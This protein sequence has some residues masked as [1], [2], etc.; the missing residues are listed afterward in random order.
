MKRCIR[1]R[2]N[3]VIAELQSITFNEYLPAVLG[4]DAISPYQGYD[5]QVDP[6]ISNLFATAAFR[7][8]HTQLSSELKR[9]KDDGA[10]IDAGNLSLRDSFFNPDPILA[11]GID[12]VLKGLATGV[13]QE[14]DTHVVDDVRNFL[15]GPPGSGGFDLVSLNIQRGRDHG[16]PDYNSCRVQLGIGTG[17]VLCGDH[18]RPGARRGTGARPM[19]RS[20]ESMFGWGRWRKTTSAGAASAVCCSE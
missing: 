7:F 17:R 5:P 2:V 8:G 19:V 10:V 6:T 14:I 16:L 4:A 20:I 12:S 3:L 11:E 13:A 9:L 1:G 15:F 18:L